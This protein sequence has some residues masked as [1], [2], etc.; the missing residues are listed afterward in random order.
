MTRQAHSVCLGIR[1]R[2]RERLADSR[3]VLWMEVANS[4][5]QRGVIHEGEHAATN[6]EKPNSICNIPLQDGQKVC[7]IEYGE[8]P[9]PLKREPIHTQGTVG[10]KPI[11][12]APPFAE[13]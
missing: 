2:F 10:E 7:G 11:R 4:V 9:H 5:A 13:G 3:F 1:T 8:F 12:L 6:T